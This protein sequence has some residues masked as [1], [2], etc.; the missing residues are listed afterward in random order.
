LGALN[1]GLLWCRVLLGLA[2]CVGDLILLQRQ[3]L[4]QNHLNRRAYVEEKIV[5]IEEQRK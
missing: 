3:W 1:D 2:D 4:L 5:S